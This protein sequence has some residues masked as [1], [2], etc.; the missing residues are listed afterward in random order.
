M[1]PRPRHARAAPGRR[2]HAPDDRTENR[3][4]QNLSGPAHQP[5]LRSHDFGGRHGGGVGGRAVRRRGARR[6]RRP[7]GPRREQLLDE[8]QADA[9]AFARLVEAWGPLVADARYAGV[10][11]GGAE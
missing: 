11:A 3:H 7:P 4:E 2:P 10:P 1:R 5:G 8:A 6:V 9:E